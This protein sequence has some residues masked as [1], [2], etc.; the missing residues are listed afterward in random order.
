[1]HRQGDLFDLV[2]ARHSPGRLVGDTSRR[3]KQRNQDANK[4]DDDK[5][6]DQRQALVPP[7][8]FVLQIGSPN[9]NAS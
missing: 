4:S 9:F 7:G 1:M 8:A 6:F 2:H 3:Q 5:Y